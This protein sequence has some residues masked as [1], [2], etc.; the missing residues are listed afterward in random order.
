MPSVLFHSAHV[1]WLSC[2]SGGTSLPGFLVENVLHGL[3][4]DWSQCCMFRVPKR[5]SPMFTVEKG[6]SQRLEE[7]NAR[8]GYHGRT[9]E[10][11]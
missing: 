11:D 9:G 5:V 6:L 4:Q 10:G 8:S 3:D 7:S 1:S 2:P